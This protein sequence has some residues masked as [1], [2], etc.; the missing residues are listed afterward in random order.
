M[1]LLKNFTLKLQPPLNKYH[2]Q[3]CC[4]TETRMSCKERI[5]LAVLED[6][7]RSNEVRKS[8]LCIKDINLEKNVQ[9]FQVQDKATSFQAKQLLVFTYH[10]I[11][12]KNRNHSINKVTNKGYDR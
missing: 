11:K 1:T 12:P 7:I 6:G 8:L 3:D 10:V 5:L 4:K 9:H 2:F